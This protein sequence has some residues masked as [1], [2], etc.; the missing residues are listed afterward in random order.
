MHSIHGVRFVQA[1]GDKIV[2]VM[3]V[4]HA[5]KVADDASELIDAVAL[6]CFLFHR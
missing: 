4:C 1:G 6:V 3:A 2:I 5:C